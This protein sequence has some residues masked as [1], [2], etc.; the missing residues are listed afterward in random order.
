MVSAI[1]LHKRA[2]IQYIN[3][4]TYVHSIFLPFIWIFRAYLD[5]KWLF[6]HFIFIDLVAVISVIVQLFHGGSYF[7]ALA[8]FCF[9]T[10][11]IFGLNA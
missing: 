5:I 7:C 8:Q 9:Q 11:C 1:I 4:R 2:T 10:G 6:F 3:T